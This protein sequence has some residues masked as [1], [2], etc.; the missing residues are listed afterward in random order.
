[1]NA[2][3]SLHLLGQPDTSPVSLQASYGY[4]VRRDTG[5]AALQK[6]PDDW[7]SHKDLGIA[8]ASLAPD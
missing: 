5:L 6:N 7:F 1:M 8:E 3:A 4:D 2:W